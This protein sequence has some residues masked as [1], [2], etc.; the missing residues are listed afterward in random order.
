[1]PIK[2]KNVLDECKLP[3]LVKR[4]S[5]AADHKDI[6]SPDD[7][8]EESS[9]HAWLGKLVQDLADGAVAK[10]TEESGLQA[11]LRSLAGSAK[12]LFTKW[13]NLE[14]S[15]RVQILDRSQMSGKLMV[16]SGSF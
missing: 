10:A 13:S 8:H 15:H 16:I 2:N 11:A 3:T 4:W 1:M 12:D 14:A 7:H 6:A 9:D 5:E